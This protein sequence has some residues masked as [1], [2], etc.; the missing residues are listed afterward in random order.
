VRIRL[1][2]TTLEEEIWVMKNTILVKSLLLAALIAILAGPAAGV[3]G[4]D[5][6]SSARQFYELRIYTF[7]SVE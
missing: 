6:K 3:E 5:S 1:F 2:L 4:R 7:T